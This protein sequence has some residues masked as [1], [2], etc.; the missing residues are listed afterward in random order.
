LF[1]L[2]SLTMNP[3][4]AHK[5][6]SCL[7][8]ALFE[9]DLLVRG[10]ARGLSSG[11]ASSAR[12]LLSRHGAAR[13]LGIDRCGAR[14]GGFTASRRRAQG[15]QADVGQFGLTG[16]ASNVFDDDPPDSS[17]LRGA[18]PPNQKAKAR[19]PCHRSATEVGG[20]AA[21]FCALRRRNYL[22]S[23][24]P[25]VA[26]TTEDAADAIGV[27]RS[28]PLRTAPP[29]PPALTDD[30]SRSPQHRHPRIA[31]SGITGR[32]PESGGA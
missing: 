13:V 27:N 26:N 5:S 20:S 7:T 11:I 16:G 19:R 22:H 8:T 4:T 6:A 29:P 2:S 23:F 17:A 18:R 21:V 1:T 25:P 28:Q 15:P 32:S 10:P 14:G 24:T 9:R 3:R 12:L 31:N 30:R